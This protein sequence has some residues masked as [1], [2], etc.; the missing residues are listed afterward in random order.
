MLNFR[1]FCVHIESLPLAL[2]PE[3]LEGCGAST[4]V[5]G[6][7]TQPSLRT[8]V[9][10][11]SQYGLPRRLRL[12]AKTAPHFPASLLS[13]LLRDALRAPQDEGIGFLHHKWPYPEEPWNKASRRMGSTL[14]VCCLEI[15]TSPSPRR[16]GRGP[17]V[18]GIFMIASPSSCPSPRSSFESLRMTGRRNAH[19]VFSPQNSML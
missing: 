14:S 5:R 17:K 10:Q 15:E 13:P 6:Q 1:A 12:L 8:Q 7:S 4:G 19:S 16:A 3:L 11:S 2:H 9:K 18:R